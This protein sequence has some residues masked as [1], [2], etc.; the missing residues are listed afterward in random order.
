VPLSNRP[1]FVPSIT[2]LVSASAW[3]LFWLPLRHVSD[4][5]FAGAWSTVGYFFISCLLLAP[6]IVWRWRKLRAGGVALLLT[7]LFSGGAIALYILS[8]LFTTVTNALLIFYVTPV[9]STLLG[10][11]C[12]GETITGSRLLAVSLGLAGL[13]VI[14]GSEDG[15][16]IPRNVGDIIALI[17]GII[18]AYAAVRL[19]QSK[20]HAIEW[21]TAFMLCAFAVSVVCL[22]LTPEIMQPPTRES[23]VQSGFLLLCVLAA[24]A[25]PFNFAILW[26]TNRLSPGRVGLLMLLEVVVGIS[27]A[28]IVT[29]EAYGLPEAIGT[30]LILC[31]AIVDIVRTPGIAGERGT[32]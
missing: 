13:W 1:D 18:W 3:G 5:G 2:L 16:P 15:L 24:A 14:L 17:A 11:L 21:V 6:L 30:A 23:F 10:R 31:A 9:W 19:N 26:A 25:L 8:F 12:L 4:N 27:V 29:D 20:A 7:G 22:A 32:Q 28:A